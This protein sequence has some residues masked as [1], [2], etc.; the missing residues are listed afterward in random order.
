VFVKAVDSVLYFR[1]S[2]IGSC[3]PEVRH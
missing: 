2:A 1:L 3:D